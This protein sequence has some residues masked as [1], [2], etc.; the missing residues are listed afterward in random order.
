MDSIAQ[1]SFPWRSSYADYAAE[2][3][4]QVL[5]ETW[6][7]WDFLWIPPTEFSYAVPLTVGGDVSV[8]FT[9]RP[10]IP[11]PAASGDP[12]HMQRPV[13]RNPGETGVP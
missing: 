4:F 5:T 2:V 1:E 7:C 13:V 8:R 11:G 6:I 9:D 12:D 3:R 10:G